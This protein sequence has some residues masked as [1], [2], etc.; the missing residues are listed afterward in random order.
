MPFLLESYYI[1]QF[2][3]SRILSPPEGHWGKWSYEGD[4]LMTETCRGNNY[5]GA[6]LA[7]F[8][9]G[10]ESQDVFVPPPGHLGVI[11]AALVAI[12]N[13]VSGGLIT[14]TDQ[15]GAINLRMFCTDG[16][17]HQR[18]ISEAMSKK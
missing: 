5:N 2:S 16:S 8:M 6:Q 10:K 1:V 13:E 18:S 14:T 15:R 3:N 12:A 17:Y 7:V 9:Q 4:W 11:G